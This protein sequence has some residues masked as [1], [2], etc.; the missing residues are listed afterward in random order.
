MANDAGAR[1]GFV[2]QL[3][4]FCVSNHYDGADID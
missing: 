1:A 2:K 3:T 4:S